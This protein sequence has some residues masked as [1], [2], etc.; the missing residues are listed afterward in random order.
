MKIIDAYILARTKRKTR[1]I[2][3]ALVTL[4][5]S[6]LFSVLFVAVIV[7]AGLYNAANQVKD[8]GYNSRYFTY[9]FNTR[10]QTLDYPTVDTRIRSELDTELKARKITV[11]QDTHNDPS[12]ISEYGRRINKAFSASFEA[13]TK[14][15][16]ETVRKMGKPSAVYHLTRTA[17]TDE[18]TYQPDTTKD[19]QADALKKIEDEGGQ[20]GGSGKFQ[21]TQ[22]VVTV[23]KD[24]LRTQLLPGQ[25]FDWQPGQPIPVAIPYVQLEQLAGRSLTKLDAATK[26]AAYKELIAQYS[27]K[28]ITYCWRNSTAAQQLQS[29]V[30]YNH[31]AS[32]DTDKA[33]NPVAVPV[34]KDFDKAVLKKIGV[35]ADTVASD[36]KPLFEAPPLPVAQTQ[37]VQFKIVA[38]TPGGQ[39]QFGN[40]FVEAMLNAVSTLPFAFN[41]ILVPA[42]VAAQQTLFKTDPSQPAS[43]APTYLM[44]DFA[45]R[46]DQRAF[47]DNGCKGNECQD[48]VKPALQPIG[49]LAVALEGVFSFL[50]NFMLIAGGVIMGIA[51][52]LVLLTISKVIADSTKEIAVF[53]AL[54]ARRRDIA[55]IYY[56]Y[57]AMLTGS[58]LLFALVIGTTLAYGVNVI[59]GSNFTAQ[60]I[61]ST[62]AYVQDPH[63][64]L[65]GIQPVWLLAVAGALVV[66]AA[67]GVSIPVFAAIHRKLITIL[68]EE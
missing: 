35:E 52:V 60:L 33:T 6:L 15:L 2:R 1:R 9:I 28:V 37:Q 48:G 58:T 8:V 31:T 25:S 36:I 4:V 43:M 24:M 54:G 51:A 53:R 59:Y 18:L 57:G 32:N 45:N 12:Y 49:N 10:P 21:Q 38:L 16:E 62:G 46:A 3:T 42:D 20:T 55:H 63:V 22:D 50:F 61:Q 67:I 29:V 27:G 5:G 34:C 65:V 39:S 47:L 68:R 13:D 23:E 56:T 66:A 14:K 26:N 19:P 17:A 30:H 7:A 11:T 64:S 41:P 40:D 44:V